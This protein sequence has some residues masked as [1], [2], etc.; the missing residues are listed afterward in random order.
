MCVFTK[1]IIK[2]VVWTRASLLWCLDA[3]SWATPSQSH[4]SLVQLRILMI[5]CCHLPSNC[6]EFLHERQRDS[7]LVFQS[8]TRSKCLSVMSKI[9]VTVQHVTYIY[10]Y[11]ANFQQVGANAVTHSSVILSR[12]DEGLSWHGHH[13]NADLRRPTLTDTYWQSYEHSRTKPMTGKLYDG[14]WVS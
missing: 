2:H 14:L 4:Y 9:L 10:L 12:L 7:L 5:W 3:L 1:W 8:C 11:T 13:V 6:H